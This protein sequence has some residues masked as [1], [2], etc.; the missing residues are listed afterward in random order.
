MFLRVYEK[1]RREA[2]Q[3]GYQ[4]FGAWGPQILKSSQFKQ[5]V[6]VV[7]WLEAQGIAV[8]WTE[9]NLQAFVDHAF[10]TVTPTIPHVGQL[11]NLRTLRSFLRALPRSEAAPLLDVQELEQVYSRILRPGLR[12]RATLLS[13]LNLRQIRL[14]EE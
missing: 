11:K 4:A 3:R 2:G 6:V 14:H 12:E 10:I 9:V 1:V 8:M 5:S 13:H 7:E